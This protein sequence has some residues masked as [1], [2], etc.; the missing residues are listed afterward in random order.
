MK[1]P[2]KIKVLT[3][4]GSP[5][6]R[7]RF[8]GE[9]LKS[10]IIEIIER[11]KYLIKLNHR[12]DPDDLI[13]YF[14]TTTNFLPSIKKWTP[15]LLEEIKGISEGVGV[16]FKE[17][18]AMQMVAHDEGWW[19]FQKYAPSNKC[20]SLGYFR[21]EDQPTIL[22]QN[23]DLPKIFEGLEVILHIKY[24]KGSLES[25]ILSHAGFLG[26]I[27]INN[28]SVGI[29]CNSLS[30]HL[31]NSPNG[32]PFT[33]IIRFVL[34]QPTVEKAIEFINNIQH[35]SAQ[36]YIIGGLERVAC[37]ECSANKV[38]EFQLY[39]DAHRIYHTNHPLVNND[40]ITPPMNNN[41]ISTSY[42]RFSYLESQ[43]HSSS[44]SITI[45][46]V[47]NILS[48]HFGPVCVHHNNQA[49]SGYTFSSVIFLLSASPSLYVTVGPPCLTEYELF[50]F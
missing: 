15:H 41:I 13:D 49:S 50:K 12:K 7:G 45:N 39:K 28:K 21:Y 27:G 5:K 17:I 8:H 32:L 14:L 33:F 11:Y 10:M 19:F 25:Y 9:S 36:S 37:L 40:L 30:N 20:S 16:D 43:L 44:K 46:T 35:A 23:L 2:S 31:N 47:K 3:L 42:D 22:A 26:E 18:L 24:E 4:E 6:E 1:H 34:E 29:C 38:V 48:S